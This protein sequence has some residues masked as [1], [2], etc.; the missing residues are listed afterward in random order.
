MYLK[1][2]AE[3]VIDFY[4][5]GKLVAQIDEKIV[6]G[7]H[8]IVHNY[9]DAI[10]AHAFRLYAPVSLAKQILLAY[11]LYFTD[12]PSKYLHYGES[13]IYRIE[14]TDVDLQYEVWLG[15]SV[16]LRI[17]N[18]EPRIKLEQKTFAPMVS[19]HGFIYNVEIVGPEILKIINANTTDLSNLG[20]LCLGY[21]RW[22]K[23]NV[24]FK[25]TGEVASSRAPQPR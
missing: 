21:E 23:D 6:E 19:K 15:D 4:H 1:H 18:Y 8:V 2:G 17:D 9:G 20:R 16:I 25:K 3:G 7:D 10:H 12:D 11:E 13:G 5:E 22:R 14:R 24:Q